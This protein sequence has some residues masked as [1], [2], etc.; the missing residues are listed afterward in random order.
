MLDLQLEI[1]E[2]DILC[3]AYEGKCH[4]IINFIILSAK[5]YIYAMKCLRQQITVIGFTAKLFHYVMLE[6]SI[7]VR[8]NVL[9]KFE[10]K[11]HRLL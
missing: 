10:T 5:Q 7:A 6:K 4:K 8:N 3:N 2:Y 9:H 1:K 11:W